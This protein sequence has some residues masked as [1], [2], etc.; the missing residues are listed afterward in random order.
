MAGSGETRDLAR[1][2]HAPTFLMFGAILAAL[3]IASW[4]HW[5]SVV[6]RIDQQTTERLRP[7]SSHGTR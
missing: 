2:S 5:R 6:P 3:G 7:R 4:R 1:H